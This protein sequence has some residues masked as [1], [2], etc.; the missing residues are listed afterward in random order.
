MSGIQMVVCILIGLVKIWLLIFEILPML[1][2]YGILQMGINVE[3]AGGVTCIL[4]PQTLLK[5]AKIG[6]NM[7]YF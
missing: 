2:D 7:L 3:M 4:M 1:I 6:I 5:G